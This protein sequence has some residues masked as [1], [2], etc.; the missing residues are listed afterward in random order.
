PAAFEEAVDLTRC[1]FAEWKRRTHA[2]RLPLIVVAAEQMGAYEVS[3]GKGGQRQRLS[4]ILGDLQIPFLDLYPEFTK[5]G[6]VADARLKFEGHWSPVGHEWAAKSIFE[7]LKRD[8]Y[9]TIGNKGAS[10][11]QSSSR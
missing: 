9:L 8:G 11:K 1:S 4:A 5:R 3:S 6:D 2:E 7:Y 10:A